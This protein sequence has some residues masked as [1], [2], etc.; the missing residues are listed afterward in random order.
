M[1][2]TVMLSK[3]LTI[4]VSGTDQHTIDFSAVIKDTDGLA[5]VTM[6]TGTAVKFSPDGDIDANSQT[7]L[8]LS[9]SG[10]ATKE[11]F[12]VGFDK[13]LRYKGGV[14][15]ETYNINVID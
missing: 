12:Q 9:S 3:S 8:T 1:A 5:L 13:P 14:G 6:L 2:N 10:N 11:I 4:T 15:S 7:S